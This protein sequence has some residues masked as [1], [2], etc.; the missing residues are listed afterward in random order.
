MKYKRPY[1]HVNIYK[2]YLLKFINKSFVKIF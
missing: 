1:M 2:I